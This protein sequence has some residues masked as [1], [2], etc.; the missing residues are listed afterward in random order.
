MV[1][2]FP[3]VSTWGF[4]LCGILICGILRDT[5][6]FRRISGCFGGVFGEDFGSAGGSEGSFLGFFRGKKGV[7]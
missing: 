7:F 1:N 3:Y 5:K 4:F 6:R 2:K